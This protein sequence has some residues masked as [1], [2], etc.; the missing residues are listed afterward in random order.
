MSDG[1]FAFGVMLLLLGALCIASLFWPAV[2]RALR[3]RNRRTALPAPRYDARSS[4]EQFK[5]IHQP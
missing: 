2:R 1:E 3:K 5:R 4:I